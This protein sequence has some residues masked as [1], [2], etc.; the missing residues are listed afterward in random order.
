MACDEIN[1]FRIAVESL[2]KDGPTSPKFARANYFRNMCPSS[3]FV[4]NQ[5]TTRSSCTIKPSAPSDDQS[6][7]TTVAISGIN[8]GITT[9]GCNPIY[10]DIGVGFF[11]RT[12]SP[13]RRDFQGPVICK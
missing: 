10:E 1:A 3:E 7:W 8:T 13:K 12:W 5:G 2:E 4:Q 11:E 9:P 6:K